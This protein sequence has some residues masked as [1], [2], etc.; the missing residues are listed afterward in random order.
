MS[1]QTDDGDLAAKPDYLGVPG[2]GVDAYTRWEWGQFLFQSPHVDPS[3]LRSISVHS[4][5]LLHGGL[6]PEQTL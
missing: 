6:G 4:S 1:L 5:E 2:L 3:S